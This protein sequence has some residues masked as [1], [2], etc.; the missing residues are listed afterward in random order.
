MKTQ[1]QELIRSLKSINTRL[2]K[3]GMSRNQIARRH[4]LA[5]K[6]YR[7]HWGGREWSAAIVANECCQPG[8]Q[9]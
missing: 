2:E 6:G 5:R 7:G 8:E 4:R 3:E 9:E 1:T